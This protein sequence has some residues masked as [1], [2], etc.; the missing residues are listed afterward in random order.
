MLPDIL[1]IWFLS[2]A[3]VYSYIKPHRLYP[4]ILECFSMSESY[5]SKSSLDL[6]FL[7]IHLLHYS[8][9]IKTPYR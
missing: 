6:N 1:H 4:C 7:A 3:R 2:L 8:F 5:A 9:F